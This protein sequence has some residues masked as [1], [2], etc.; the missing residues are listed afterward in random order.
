MLYMVIIF[1]LFFFVIFIVFNVVV[2]GVGNEYE[3]C[4]NFFRFDGGFWVVVEEW[5]YEYFFVF[6]D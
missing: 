2:V 6:F 1:V 3:V 4:F 5:V